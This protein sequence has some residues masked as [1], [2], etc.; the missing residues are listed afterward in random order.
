MSSGIKRAYEPPAP[1][2]GERILVDRLR[3]RGLRK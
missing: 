2:D 3:P 1:G